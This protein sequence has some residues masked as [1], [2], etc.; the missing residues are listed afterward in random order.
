M[1]GETPSKPAAQLNSTLQLKLQQCIDGSV[2]E[3]S[4]ILSTADQ[5]IQLRQKQL[6]YEKQPKSCKKH[7]GQKII[8]GPKC[9]A[10]TNCSTK[11]F[12]QCREFQAGKCS[13]GDACKFIHSDK[14]SNHNVFEEPDEDPPS[15]W[16][17]TDQ[18]DIDS[19]VSIYSWQLLL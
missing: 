7:R 18:L 2:C 16:H 11:E 10:G 6:G 13:Y 19:D 12:H 3:E 8:V 5:L 4:S 1:P 17:M 15:A 9:A 14:P